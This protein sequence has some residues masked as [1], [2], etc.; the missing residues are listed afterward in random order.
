[1]DRPTPAAIEHPQSQRPALP[2]YVADRWPANRSSVDNAP[3][4]DMPAIYTFTALDGSDFS[5]DLWTK[6]RFTISLDYEPNFQIYA[7]TP[8]EALTMVITRYSDL[9]FLDQYYPLLGGLK[10]FVRVS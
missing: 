2:R 1:V 8:C 6:Q 7:H 3:S 5:I 9:A 4:V 10:H